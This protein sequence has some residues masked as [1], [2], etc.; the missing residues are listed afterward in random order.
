MLENEGFRFENYV[1]IFDAGPTITAPLQQIRAVRE[2]RYAQVNISSD[3]AEELP[4]NHFLISNTQQTNFR[5]ALE[6]VQEIAGT[7]HISAKLANILQVKDNDQVRLV[8][9]KGARS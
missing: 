4:S 7:V 5:C 8:E 6:Y 9:L 3:T 2:S 1:D